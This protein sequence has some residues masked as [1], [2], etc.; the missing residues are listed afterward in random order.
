VHNKLFSFKHKKETAMRHRIPY[1]SFNT[2]FNAMHG[3]LKIAF[4]VT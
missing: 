2:L 1:P 4:A 3:C